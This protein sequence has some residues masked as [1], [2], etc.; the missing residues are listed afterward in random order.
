MKTTKPAAVFSTCTVTENFVKSNIGLR[1]HREYHFLTFLFPS[2][3][4]EKLNSK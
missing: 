2:R 3:S 4:D 1:K